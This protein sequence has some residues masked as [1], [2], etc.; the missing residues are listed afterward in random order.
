MLKNVLIPA[1]LVL[2]Q[3]SAVGS[4]T[5]RRAGWSAGTL[6]A[7]LASEQLC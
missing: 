6:P 5:F 7:Q 1:W 3:A 4:A 2:N